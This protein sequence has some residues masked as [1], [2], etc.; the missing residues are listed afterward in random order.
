MATDNTQHPVTPAGRTLRAVHIMG[1]LALLAPVAYV[2]GRLG[3]TALTATY[4]HVISPVVVATSLGLM[5]GI[6]IGL[7]F[8]AQKSTVIPAPIHP[9]ADK[10]LAQE[11]DILAQIRQELQ[12]I[13]ILFA[14]RRGD[15]TVLSRIAYPTEYWTALKAS[16]QLFVMRNPALLNI[17]AAAYYW[18]EQASR[19][20]ILAF[21]TRYSGAAVDNQNASTH[22]VADARLL[23]GPLETSLKAAIAAIDAAL[24]ASRQAAATAPPPSA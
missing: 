16:G 6:P 21:E 22:L 7:F 24:D 13:D 8:G 1:L 4:F 18:V 2:L 10:I 11:D 12:Q 14:P 23:D 3:V 20:E 19:L 17:I 15:Q 5:L 9:H